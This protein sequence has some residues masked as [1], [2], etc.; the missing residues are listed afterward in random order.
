ME[1]PEE[2]VSELRSVISAF[3]TADFTSFKNEGGSLEE[4]GRS[5]HEIKKKLLPY[6]VHE[7]RMQAGLRPEEHFFRPD[8]PSLHD[9]S[10]AEPK[11]F[12]PYSPLIGVMN[13]ISPPFYFWKD[14][15]ELLGRGAFDSQYCGP[16]EAVHGGHVAALLDELL[17]VT[18][19][20]SGY[21]GFTG[22]LTVRYE[23]TTPLDKELELKGWVEDVQDRKVTICGELRSEET[24][25][26]TA[27]GIF[28]R[29]RE[30]G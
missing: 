23:A 3:R 8:T 13:P 15:D 17:G 1:S 29:P 16:P 2:L 19:V 27:E 9:M 5:L 10:E 7:E 11:E 21:G 28:I 30:I 25:C 18:G 6:Q 12:F 4:L 22:T 26:A 14:G 24:I 20:V